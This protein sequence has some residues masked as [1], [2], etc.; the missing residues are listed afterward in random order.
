MAEL[1]ANLSTAQQ[2]LANA[3]FAN[4]INVT[5]TSADPKAVVDALVKW[6]KQNGKLP[7]SVKVS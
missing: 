7:P 4:Q 6:S 2:N 3:R 5:V 1:G